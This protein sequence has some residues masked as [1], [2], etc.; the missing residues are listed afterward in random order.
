[1]ISLIYKIEQTEN[2]IYV[3]AVVEDMVQIYAQTYYEPAEYGP[4][5]CEASFSLSDD[6]VLP[7][8]E[9]EIIDYLESLELEWKIIKDDFE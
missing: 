5:L 4:A 1:M 3:Q 8:N 6:E 9:D 2:E 7:V